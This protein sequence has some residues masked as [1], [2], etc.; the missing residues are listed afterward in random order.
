MSGD[1]G[2]ENESRIRETVSWNGIFKAKCFMDNHIYFGFKFDFFRN[3][4][5]YENSHGRKIK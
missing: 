2:E 1:T 4:F 3:Q 5:V